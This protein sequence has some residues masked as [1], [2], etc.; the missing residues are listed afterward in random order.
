MDVVSLQ[1]LGCLA[2]ASRILFSKYGDASGLS[3]YL[4][5][6]QSL[7]VQCLFPHLDGSATQGRHRG[8]VGLKADIRYRDITRP[9]MWDCM[10]EAQPVVVLS[11]KGREL[12]NLPNEE[13][14]V[15]LSV[16]VSALRIYSPIHCSP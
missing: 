10:V 2:N 4:T 9:C 12:G 6:P 5:K 15:T 8:C 14:A 7:V 11:I 13:I 3:I 1:G 16:R